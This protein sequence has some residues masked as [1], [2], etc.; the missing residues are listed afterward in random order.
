MYFGLWCLSFFLL[1]CFKNG[2]FALE[3]TLSH[4]FNTKASY[5]MKAR[6]FVFWAVSH[7]HFYFLFI[8]KNE[9]FVLERK[10]NYFSFFL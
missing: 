8:F 4:F 2:C 6:L 7:S 5:L 1:F 9:G 3:R 10:L